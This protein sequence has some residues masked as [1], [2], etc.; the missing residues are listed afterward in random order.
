MIPFLMARHHGQ[1]PGSRQY[2][3]DAACFTSGDIIASIA[4]TDQKIGTGMGEIM[5]ISD[6]KPQQADGFA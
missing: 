2:G 3:N 1:S 4:G 6:Q 5:L